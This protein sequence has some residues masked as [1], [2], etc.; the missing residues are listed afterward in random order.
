MVAQLVI[1]EM[2]SYSKYKQPPKLFLPRG[3]ILTKTF[4]FK[5]W[6]AVFVSANNPGAMEMADELH[7][8]YGAAGLTISR[9]MPPEF[10]AYN[11]DPVGGR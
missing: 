2:S 8:K 7:G 4:H 3:D 9:Q 11:I 5:A 6:T 10:A 1:H